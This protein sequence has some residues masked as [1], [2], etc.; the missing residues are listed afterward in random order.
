MSEYHNLPSLWFMLRHQRQ[1]VGWMLI[2]GRLVEQCT[3][4]ERL[5]ALTRSKSMDWF[6]YDDGLRHE[7]VKYWLQKQPS[8]GVLKIC[9]K[10]TGDHHPCRIAISVKLFYDYIEIALRHGCSPVNLMHIFRTIF[11]K[12]T[13]GLLPLWFTVNPAKHQ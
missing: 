6:L 1:Y 10:F 8:R 7:R 11:P 2:S 13:S 5:S 3:S 4:L 9:S 12:N